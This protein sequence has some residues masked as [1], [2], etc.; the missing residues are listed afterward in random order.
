M[1][2][3]EFKEIWQNGMI[4]AEKKSPAFQ[5]RWCEKTQLQIT[6]GALVDMKWWQCPQ[7]VCN[8][9]VCDPL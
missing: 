8:Q 7:F 4:H 1:N 9:G 2:E 6:F 5:G 3:N